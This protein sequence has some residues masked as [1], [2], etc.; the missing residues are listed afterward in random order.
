MFLYA[1]RIDTSSK[2]EDEKPAAGLAE[3][4]QKTFD[5]AAF[6]PGMWQHNAAVEQAFDVYNDKLEAELGVKLQNPIRSQATDAPG[7]SM[8]ARVAMYLS[9]DGR[10]PLMGGSVDKDP[11]ALH[12]A[13]VDRLAA[14]YPDR[15]DLIKPS[16][17]PAARVFEEMKRREVAAIDVTDRAAMPARVNLPAIGEMSLNPAVLAGSFAGSMMDPLQAGLNIAAGPMARVGVGAKAVLFNAAKVAA[18][19]AALEAAQQPLIQSWRA[20]AGL[21]H[22][23]DMALKSTVAAGA[24]GF[25]LDAGVRGAARGVRGAQGFEPKLDASGG[26]SGWQRPDAK[27]DPL[28][29]LDAAARELPDDDILRRAAVG[30]PDALRQVVRDAGVANDPEVRGALDALDAEDLFGR[31]PDGV[32]ASEHAARLDDAMRA[33]SNRDALP[34]GDALVV[35]HNEDAGPARVAEVLADDPLVLAAKIRETPDLLKEGLPWQ[36]AP[37][38]AAALLS[39]LSEPAFEMVA[40]GAVEPRLGVLVADHIADASLHAGL[41]RRLQEAGPRDPAEARQVLARLIDTPRDARAHAVIAG[42]AAPDRVAARARVSLLDDPHGPEALRQL[43]DLKQRYADDLGDLA[44]EPG[45]KPKAEAKPKADGKSDAKA[46][47]AAEGSAKETADRL[48]ARIADAIERALPRLPDGVTVKAFVTADELPANLRRGVEYA[49]QNG[50]AVN[51]LT[52]RQTGNIWIAADA[53]DPDGTLS[54]ETIHALRQT[55][56]LTTKELKVLAREAAKRPDIFDRAAYEQLYA[57]QANAADA[58]LQ[59]A[60]AHLYEARAAGHTFGGE[61]NA[62]LYKIRQFLDRVRNSLQ[63]LGFKTADDI[64]RAVDAGDVG[65]RGRGDIA[66]P[67]IREVELPGGVKVQGVALFSI[68]AHH[69]SPHDFEKFSMEKIGTGEGAQAFGHGLYFADTE[70]VAKTY[71]DN[72]AGKDVSV[73]GQKVTYGAGNSYADRLLNQFIHWDNGDM[74][75]VIRRLRDEVKIAAERGI[76]SDDEGVQDFH[77]ALA[78]AEKIEADNAASVNAKGHLYQVRIDANPEDFLDWDK[79]L[80]QQSEKVK[81]MLGVPSADKIAE[82]ERLAKEIERLN[83]QIDGNGFGGMHPDEA[84]RK[85]DDVVRQYLEI[86]PT[87]SAWWKNDARDAAARPESAAKLREVGILGI[88]YL[89][90]NSRGQGEG[91]YNYVVFDDSLIEITHKNGVPVSSPAEALFSIDRLR[92][93]SGKFRP[94]KES[95]EMLQQDFADILE[96]FQ[97][98]QAANPGDLLKLQ[99]AEREMRHKQRMALIDHEVRLKNERFVTSLKDARGQIDPAK[100]LVFLIE[101]HGE[102]AMPEGMTSVTAEAKAIEGMAKAHM[103]QMLHEFRPKLGVGGTRN[104]ARVS[105]IVREIAGEATGDAAAKDMAKTWLSVAE[106]LRQEFNAAGGDI[107]KLEGWILPQAHD[108][109]ALLAASEEVWVN[110]TFALLALDRIVDAETRKPLPANEIMQALRD[111][112]QN[113]TS[114]G[115]GTQRANARDPFGGVDDGIGTGKKIANQRLEHRFLHFKN[116]DAWLDYQKQYGGGGDPF[117]AMMSHITSM[118]K[119]IAALRVLGTNPD[120]ELARLSNFAMKQARL[121]WPAAKRIEQAVSR[122]KALQAELLKAPSRANEVMDRIGMIHKEIDAIRSKGMGKLSRR[123][124]Q[125]IEA[126]HK[127]LFPLNDEWTKITTQSG[128]ERVPSYEAAVILDKLNAAYD[129]LGAIQDETKV[130]FPKKT[131]ILS[132]RMDVSDPRWYKWS[133]NPEDYAKGK[134]AQADAMWQMF[135]GATSTPQ[136]LKAATFMQDARNLG[137]IGRGGS[138]VISSIADNFTQLM[139]RKFVGVPMAKTLT[140]IVGQFSTGNRREAM[141]AALIGET[142][143]HMF[144]D[145]ARAAAG[146]RGGQWSNYLAERTIALQ[147]L[148][149]LTDAQRQAFG[150]TLQGIVSDLAPKA[151]AEIAAEMPGIAKVFKRY[152][153]SA[154]D[155]DAIRLDPATGK[156]RDV[157]FISPNLV[158]DSLEEAGR[159]AE[160]IAERYLGMVLQ[161][162]DFASPTAMLRARTL[163]VGT[164]RPGTF[165][166]EALRVGTQFKSFAVMFWML[167]A[168]RAMREGISSGALSGAQYG[169]AV[170]V[171]TTLAGALVIQLKGMRSGQEAQNMDPFEN[172]TFWGRA[173]IQGGGL[174]IWGDLIAS[175]TNRFG[176]GMISTLSGPV[177]GIVEDMAMPLVNLKQKNRPAFAHDLSKLATG[178]VP[179]SSLWYTTLAYKRF[180]TD[181]VQ[182]ALDPDAHQAFA[183]ARQRQRKEYGNDFWWAPGTRAPRGGVNLGQALGR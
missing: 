170:V 20:R 67:A 172:P 108:R 86:D 146:V 49:R 3:V 152:G 1:P 85:K 102:V 88:R 180:V 43:E 118:S 30:E 162:S 119:D 51:G 76:P 140:D 92:D 14:Q 134:I 174:G 31:A 156:P 163:L 171:A 78:K 111:I 11:F 73:Y 81:Q 183:R 137:V 10:I 18:A 139:A 113:I 179:G 22:G 55:G 129:E 161:E 144:N 130:L 150:M 149:R 127:E 165:L 50:Y 141:R 57:G 83:R 47:A 98:Q 125:K 131:E 58:L 157:D 36:D 25:A 32:D 106:R 122:M 143:L 138:M 70:S 175:E 100:A 105:N 120:R 46:E 62:I 33:V 128:A 154:S 2:A 8:A 90:G 84:M 60:A 17:G 121:A 7:V 61:A 74:E 39:R 53:L 117:G 101:H 4:A 35:P 79:P 40:G 64:F 114:D 97:R 182:K 168:E 82:A 103:E 27:A 115:A 126:L 93:G 24:F 38:R 107:A 26:V 69:G 178:Y 99:A 16:G 148:N 56:R 145:G 135:R 12:A 124:K 54:H 91:S 44:L 42:G 19:N 21:D 52:D 116:A 65:K 123:S 23:F 112:W 164:T 173:L 72:L 37:M 147:G 48:H 9:S 89:D 68:T 136:N 166:G 151:M 181:E 109:A 94:G 153:L 95:A 133:T 59:E 177:V 41:L 15:L 160:R 63:G 104:L 66:G 167:H 110:D 13:E 87:E 75:K 71:R 45:A 176:G 132:K 34:P 77:R 28:G 6:R 96:D 29:A 5:D 158:R 80:S 155:W 169:A 142:Y 159:G